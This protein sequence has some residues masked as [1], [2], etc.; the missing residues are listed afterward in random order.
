MLIRDGNGD[1]HY[2]EG[3]LCNVVGQKFDVHGAVIPEPLAATE[4]DRVLRQTM[5]A[6]CIR[7]SQ[8]YSNK[9]AIQPPAI[10]RVDIKPAYVSYVGQ[11]PFQSRPCEN[12][13]DHTEKLEGIVYGI[14][15]HTGTEDYLLYKLFKYFFGECG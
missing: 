7:L 3:H 13:M 4:D 9:S 10:K 2:P 12:P 6:E 1:Q 15:E 14:N 5:I 11:K 8:F